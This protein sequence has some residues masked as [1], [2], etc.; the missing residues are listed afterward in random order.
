MNVGIKVPNTKTIGRDLG[1]F[2]KTIS[3]G[4]ANI[5]DKL[6]RSIDES[7]GKVAEQT[8]LG[9]YDV[10]DVGFDESAFRDTSRSQKQID[11][12][13][14]QREALLHQRKFQGASAAQL[15]DANLM[16]AQMMQGAQMARDDLEFR[17]GQKDLV[18]ALQQQAAGQ[19]PSLASAQLDDARQQ[20][21][22][23]AM[24]LAAS[25]RGLGA[26]Q[27]L[28]SIADQ[29]A[30]AGQFAAREAAKARI[31]EQLGAREQLAGVLQGA[32][33]Q[34]I[35]VASSQAS[36]DQQAAM[37]NQAAA[38]QAEQA[39]QAALNQFDLTQAGMD[40]QTNI[41]NMQAQLDFQQQQDA[42]QNILNQQIQGLSMGQQQNLMDLERMK[43]QR[44]LELE[45]MRAGAY[46]A[47]GK[48]VTNFVGAVGQGVTT[49]AG[50]S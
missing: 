32:R 6:K 42:F 10:Q 11:W 22:E 18:S 27:G 34:D 44:D 50:G 3:T 43:M 28:R 7:L 13:D 24:A 12:L 26:G 48:N 31:A 40:Q 35:G 29:T 4:G 1:N 5:A 16:N 33:G 23:T 25:Q 38:M 9:K 8:G 36:L 39:N 46:A 15:G 20:Q 19:G 37:A 21:I 41:A 17:R 45:A 14:A 49:V 2:Q 30:Q 47:R